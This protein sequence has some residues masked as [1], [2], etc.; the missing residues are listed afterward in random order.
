MAFGGELAMFAA[1]GFVVLG[2]K[3]MHHLLRTIQ[4]WKAEATNIRNSIES[5]IRCGSEC[6]VGVAESDQARKD[7][8]A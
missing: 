6:G 2:P 4:H 5:E 1:L 3:R 8:S 7:I